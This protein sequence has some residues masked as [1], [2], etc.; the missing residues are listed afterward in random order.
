L[1]GHNLFRYNWLWLGAF[2]AIALK[3]AQDESFDDD[4][5]PYDDDGVDAWSGATA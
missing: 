4:L 2:Q 1:G 5:E 3:C